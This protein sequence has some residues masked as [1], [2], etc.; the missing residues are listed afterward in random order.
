MAPERIRVPALALVRAPVPEMMPPTV[1]G[2][3]PKTA[4][5]RAPVPRA[6][7]PVPRLTAW[8][9]PNCRP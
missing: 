9:P 3:E 5:V 2:A 1:S 7:A 6:T 8:V 4:K